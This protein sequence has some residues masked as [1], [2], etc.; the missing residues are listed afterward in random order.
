M[1]GRTQGGAGSENA[2]ERG[3]SRAQQLDRQ[4]NELLQELRVTQTGIQLLTGFLLI[5]PFQGR[6][7]DLGRHLVIAYLVAVALAILATGLVVAPVV[8]HRRMF[9]QHR[10][11][12]L[13]DLGHRFAQAGLL[14]LGLAVTAAAGLTFAFVAGDSV[15]V[16]AGVVVAVVF[17][18]LWFA[19][20]ELAGRRTSGDARYGEE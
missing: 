4:W 1:N 6:F 11:D 9:R 17:F 19:V 12:A 13:V 3:E 7:L 5:L 18:T 14:T 10:K 15:G 16:G 2:E 20:P 8:A